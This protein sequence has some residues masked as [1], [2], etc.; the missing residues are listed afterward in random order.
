LTK[1][2]KC[3]IIS[4]QGEERWVFIHS[5]PLFSFVFST[6]EFL[7]P[8]FIVVQSPPTETFSSYEEALQLAANCHSDGEEVAIYEVVSRFVPSKVVFHQ[9]KL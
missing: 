5:F 7:M 3:V 2:E 8:K 1:L 4:V 9:E 6:Q